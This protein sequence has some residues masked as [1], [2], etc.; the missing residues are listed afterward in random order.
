VAVL[1]R[2]ARPLA[3]L[4]EFDHGSRS[5]IVTPH[6]GQ[7]VRDTRSA[8]VLLLL[9]PDDGGQVRWTYAQLRAACLGAGGKQ[10]RTRAQCVSL[11][12]VT[13]TQPPLDVKPVAMRARGNYA[14]GISWSDAH[15]S[16]YPHRTLLDG[17][18]SAAA[19]A[20]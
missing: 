14:I 5:V 1:S 15:D 4:V 3:P 7:Q 19:R 10:V 6:E 20:Q 12:L 8:P 11:L 13:L 9:L 18:P 17:P 2:G 16:I